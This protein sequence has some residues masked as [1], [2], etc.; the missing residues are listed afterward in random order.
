MTKLA[1]PAAPELD[2]SLNGWEAGLTKEELPLDSR[3]MDTMQKRM[4]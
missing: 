3:K 4:P 2:G 1:N